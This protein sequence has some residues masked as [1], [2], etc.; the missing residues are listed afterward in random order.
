M[1]RLAENM[2][3]ET[4][5]LAFHGFRPREPMITDLAVELQKLGL[6]SRDTVVL[7]FLSNSA[8]MGTDSYGLPT[9]AIRAEDGSYHVIGSLTVA[10]ISCAKKVLSACTPIAEALKNM[11]VVLLSPVPRYMHTKCCEDPTHVENFDDPDLDEEIG[12]VLRDTS[13]SCRTGELK[14]SY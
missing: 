7:D 11:G 12:E 8:F 9:E 4:I 3:P 1:I 13:G 5:S 10:P 2:G 14:R 6:G